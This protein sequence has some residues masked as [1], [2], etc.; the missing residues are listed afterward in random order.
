MSTKPL[1][2]LDVDG[3][4]NA[5][6]PRRPH[7][8]RKAQTGRT[9]KGLPITYTLHFDNEVA[10]MIETLQDHFDVVW[11]TMWNHA[12]NTELV[13]MLGIDEMPVM[14]CSHND[15]LD[16]LD[17]QGYDFRQAQRLWYAKTPL[18]P[19]Y[20]G[21]TPFVW[22]DDDH[23]DADRRYLAAQMDQPFRLIKTDAYDGLTWDDVNAAIAFARTLNPT[24]V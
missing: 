9:N 7:V 4:V 23:S 8:V 18:V 19:A 24:S 12:A 3:V 6:A 14:H 16:I 5:F 2:L 20:V 13:P 22:I 10:A 11:C 21:D 15:G 17:D 1:L